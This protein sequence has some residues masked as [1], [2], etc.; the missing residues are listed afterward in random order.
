MLTKHTSKAYHKSAIVRADEFCQVMNNQ[1]SDI[2]CQ[3]NRAMA[4]RVTSNRMKLASIVQTIVFC[5][6]QNIPLRGHRDSA[7]DLERDAPE[8]HGNFWALLRFRVE[9]GDTILEQHLSTWAR[10][11]SYT[12]STVQNQIIDIVSNQIQQAIL[13][14]AQWFTV[15]T[16][17]V[18]DLSNKEL[19]SLVLRYVDHDTGL[20]REDL[21][22]FLECDTGI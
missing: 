6:R 7:T 9:S 13:K 22:D 17:K 4:D 14:K 19:L 21:M 16:D 12:S 8:N 15:I 2:R 20:A 18:T 5:G 3:M 11:A 10:N 1:Q